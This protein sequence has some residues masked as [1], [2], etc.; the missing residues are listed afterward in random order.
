LSGRTEGAG[1]DAGPMASTER[2]ALVAVGAILVASIC[3]TFLAE[4]LESRY[5]GPRLIDCRAALRKGDEMGYFRHGST[6]LVFATP[7]LVPVA[8]LREG[9]RI[10]MGEALLSCV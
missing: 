7:G 2:V 1:R 9:Q 3:L 4:P 10:R 5:A 8:A 6:I